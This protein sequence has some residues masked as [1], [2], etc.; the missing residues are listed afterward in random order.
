MLDR[1]TPSQIPQVAR[2]KPIDL[3]LAPPH[4]P[5][6]GNPYDALF[7]AEFVGPC[8]E[9]VTIPG[10]YDE[11][12]GY[13]VR[14]SPTHEGAWRYTTRSGVVALDGVTGGMECSPNRNPVM[15]GPLCVDPDH[16]RHF[17]YADGTRCFPLGYEVDWLPV[18]DEGDTSLRRVESFLDGILRAGF[19]LVTFNTFAY[20]ARDWVDESCERDPRY[21]RPERAPWQGGNLRPDYSRMDGAFFAQCDRVI[22]ALLRRGMLAHMMIHVYNKQVNWPVLGSPDDDRYWRYVLARYQAFPNMIWDPS[23]EPFYQPAEYIWGR[24]ALIRHL[25]GY[26]RLLTVHDAN[27]PQLPNP[28][29]RR[30]HDPRKDRTD[31]LADVKSD[32]IHSD[33]YGDAVRNYRA[34]P[35]PYINIEY[36]YERGVEEL[37]TYG[38]RQDWREVLRRTWH[39]TMGGAYANYYYSNTAWNLFVPHPEPPGYR[40]H[41]LYRDFWESTRYWLLA[42]DARPLGHSTRDGVFCRALGGEEYVVWDETGQGFELIVSQPS[43]SLRA[44]WFDPLTGERAGGGELQAGTHRLRAPWEDGRWAVLHARI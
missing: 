33:W 2:Y 12:L 31:S 44:T 35:R 10:F 18:I 40:V 38:V 42:P 20:A 6:P 30:Y 19:D 8:G 3:L 27:L 25:D 36:G 11:T 15:H 16:P 23:K 13:V 1:T 5:V 39:V 9:A 17:L 4:A 37:P 41:R 14:F 26:G 28:W 21:V 7:E 29:S 43:R 24:I 22:L 34:A 32:Q